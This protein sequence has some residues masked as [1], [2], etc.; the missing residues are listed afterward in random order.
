MHESEALGAYA[1]KVRE[2]TPMPHSHAVIVDDDDAI[3]WIEGQG[4]YAE[5]ILTSPKYNGVPCKAAVGGDM[6][7]AAGGALHNRVIRRGEHVIVALVDGDPNGHAVIISRAPTTASNPASE[8]AFREIT[9][10]NLGRTNADLFGPGESWHV[11]LR[12]GGSLFLRVEDDGNVAINTKGGSFC[13][14]AKSD[15]WQVKHRDGASVQVNSKAVTLKSPGAR[16][17]I[18]VRDDGIDI[19]SAGVTK[20]LGKNGLFLNVSTKDA[21]TFKAQAVAY[22]ISGPPGATPVGRSFS[23]FVGV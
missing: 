16:S 14:S 1:E 6:Y 21:A 20:L 2:G 15:A 4:L 8:V 23:V 9:E 22:A 13:Y 5:L 12:G 10:K 3:H 19:V 17:W 7:Y 18:E 11:G